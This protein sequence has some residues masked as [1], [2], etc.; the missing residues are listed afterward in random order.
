[1]SLSCSGSGSLNSNFSFK[2]SRSGCLWAASYA[3]NIS[4]SCSGSGSLNLNT[5]FSGSGVGSLWA[6][7]LSTTAS[8]SSADSLVASTVSWLL[9]EL[10]DSLGLENELEEYK[11]LDFLSGVLPT[12]SLSLLFL[13]LI[14]EEPSVKSSFS[15]VWHQI[16]LSVNLLVS[17]SY[18]KDN[19]SLPHRSSFNKS[20]SNPHIYKPEHI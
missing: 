15:W 20:R 19:R 13:Q 1:M 3:S 6:F 14:G 5:S 16:P 8:I 4:F 2:C 9:L 11:V 18:L 7:N 10:R 17:Q 12:Q